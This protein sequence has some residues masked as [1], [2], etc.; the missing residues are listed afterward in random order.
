MDPLDEQVDLSPARHVLPYDTAVASDLRKGWVAFN[1]GL[2]RIVE[3]RRSL[4]TL[5][6]APTSAPVNVTVAG[7]HRTG[8]ISM[9]HGRTV[10]EHLL[11]RGERPPSGVRVLMLADLLLGSGPE[12]WIDAADLGQ[13]KNAGD[14]ELLTPGLRPPL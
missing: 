5:S 13:L 6:V 9:L 11:H 14:S 10:P 1:S 8:A 4:T 7:L 2:D 12:H 3:L